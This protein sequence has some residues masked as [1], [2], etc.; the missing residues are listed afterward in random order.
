MAEALLVAAGQQAGARRAAVRA[1]D[2]ALRAADAVLGDR[3]DVRRRDVL[4]AVDADVGV[5]EVVGQDDDDV[6]FR[7]FASSVLAEAGPMETRKR[8][9]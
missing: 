3:V 1:R 7:G 4:A 5:A 6:G 2:V 8:K 9:G